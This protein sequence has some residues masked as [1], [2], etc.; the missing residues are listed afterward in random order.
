MAA[1]YYTVA[2]TDELPPGD[3]IIVEIGHHIIAVFNV[4]GRYFAIR[5]V[6]THDDGPLADGKIYDC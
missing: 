3:R 1:Q 6:C 4:D 2:T 5:D